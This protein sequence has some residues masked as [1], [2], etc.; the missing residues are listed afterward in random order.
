MSK[1]REHVFAASPEKVYA[2][3]SKM[4]I[5]NATAID[6]QYAECSDISKINYTYGEKS[7]I[8]VKVTEVV[9]NQMIKYQTAME[10]RE[11]YDVRFDLLPDGENTKLIYD[12]D[13]V[14]DI[15]RI[16]TNYNFMRFFY[17]WKQKKAFKNM[18]AYLQSVI[19]EN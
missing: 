10:K 15:K 4:L 13:I 17:T 2:A 9:E 5:L 18:C 12:I 3:I 16:E 6:K 1:P 8:S 19:D 14:T 7:K 11:R